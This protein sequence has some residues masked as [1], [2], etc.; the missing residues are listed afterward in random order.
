[1]IYIHIYKAQDHPKIYSKRKLIENLAHYLDI[2]PAELNI[3]RNKNG[4][5]EV[6][7][8]DFSI[9][10]SHNSVVQAFTKTGKVGIDVEHKNST[11][12]HLQIAQRYFHQNEYRHLKAQSPADMITIFYNLWTAKEAVCKAQGGRLWYYLADNYLT[13]NNTSN[14]TMAKTVKGLNLFNLDNISGFALTIATAGKTDE[15]T[16][17]Y[18]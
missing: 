8:I 12:K 2:E 13:S 4:K 3:Q 16:F 5:P 6:Q 9:S 14:N 17:I 7:G 10:H 15:M 18:E 11:R 1:M